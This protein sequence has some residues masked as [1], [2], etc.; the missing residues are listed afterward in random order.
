MRLELTWPDKMVSQFHLRPRTETALAWPSSR[1]GSSPLA[2]RG[3]AAPA[4]QQP[5][6]RCWSFGSGGAGQLGWEVFQVEKLRWPWAFGTL[7][8]AGLD[9]EGKQCQLAVRA[10]DRGGDTLRHPPPGRY[11]KLEQKEVT[12]GWRIHF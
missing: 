8:Q 6:L 4:R 1:S 12:L 3:C 5:A 7:L 10:W 9:D 11:G 2:G